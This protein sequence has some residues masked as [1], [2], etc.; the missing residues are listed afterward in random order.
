MTAATAGQLA[1]EMLANPDTPEYLQDPRLRALIMKWAEARAAVLHL[2]PAFDAA[3]EAGDS[4]AISD[5]G[6][7]LVLAE[8]QALSGL[9]NLGLTPLAR[10]EGYPRLP[11]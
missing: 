3:L 6:E 4:F 1:G 11:G 8:E 7:M 2:W 9:R 10:A 5:I